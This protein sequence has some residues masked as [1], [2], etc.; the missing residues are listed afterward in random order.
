MFLIGLLWFFFVLCVWFVDV[1]F[2][3]EI[4]K[5]GDCVDVLF[6]WLMSWFIFLEVMFFV[7]FFGVLFYVC[8]IVM[9]WFGDLNNKLLWFDFNVLWLNVGLVGMVML[10]MMMGLWLI[11][12]INMVLLLIFGVMFMWV[13]YVLCEGKCV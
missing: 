8:M 4:G 10:F 12:I 9:L 1:I 3:F 5:Y 11:L 7:V 6:C 13:Y 2:E